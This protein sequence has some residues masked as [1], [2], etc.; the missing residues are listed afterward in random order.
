MKKKE[1]K[2]KGIKKEIK[3]NL[4]KLTDSYFERLNGDI[5]Q[6]IRKVE[7]VYA[8]DK[9]KEKADTEYMHFINTQNRESE[10]LNK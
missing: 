8:Y 6:L 5:D 10:F 7:T 4:L 1:N 2:W 9:V 3:A